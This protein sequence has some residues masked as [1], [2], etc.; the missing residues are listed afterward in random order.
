LLVGSGP[1]M[2]K[3][4]Q[5][6]RHGGGELANWFKL[7]YEYG[8]IGY[9]I[10]ICFLASCLR[11]SRCPGVVIAAIIFAFLFLQGIMTIII[12]L[13]TLN[14]PEHRRRRIDEGSRYEPPLVTG[15]A[16]N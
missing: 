4:F 14:G 8:I 5:D 1:G 6:T 15:S 12:P 2:A 7:F 10:F 3:T 11:R 13:C 9:F 16:A